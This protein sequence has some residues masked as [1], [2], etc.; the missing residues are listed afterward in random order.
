MPRAPMSSFRFRWG[1]SFAIAHIGVELTDSRVGVNWHHDAHGRAVYDVLARAASRPCVHSVGAPL[2]A[3][4]KDVVRATHE[5][6]SISR[7]R[8]SGVSVRLW[9]QRAAREEMF[10]LRIA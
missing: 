2:S 9:R 8:R 4:Q 5:Y 1:P 3:R 10:A 7:S 6:S